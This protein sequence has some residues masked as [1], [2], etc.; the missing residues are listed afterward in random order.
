MGWLPDFQAKVEFTSLDHHIQPPVRTLRFRPSCVSYKI[1]RASKSLSK[2][3][4]ASDD[5]AW[6]DSPVMSRNHAEIYIN[7]D[8]ESIMLKDIGSLHGTFIN[9]TQVE[10]FTPIPI[11]AGDTIV[12]GAPVARN[13]ETFP[14]CSFQVYVDL[15]DTTAYSNTF[16]LPSSSDVEEEPYNIISDDER[17]HVD[18]S[19]SSDASSVVEEVFITKAANVEHIGDEIVSSFSAANDNG[20]HIVIDSDE[21]MSVSV[22]DLESEVADSDSSDSASEDIQEDEIEELE[23]QATG[24]TVHESEMAEYSDYNQNTTSDNADNSDMEPSAQQSYGIR[25]EVPDDMSDDEI[26]DDQQEH[27]SDTELKDMARLSNEPKTSPDAPWLQASSFKFVAEAPD[28]FGVS[29]TKLPDI[30]MPPQRIYAGPYSLPPMNKP[31]IPGTLQTPGE[32][33]EGSTSNITDSMSDKKE[34]FDAW[35][36]NRETLLKQANITPP[37]P[38]QNSHDNSFLQVEREFSPTP[39]YGHGKIAEQDPGTEFDMTSAVT[40]N[41]SKQV[42]IPSSTPL[43][44]E[45]SILTKS[46]PI[47]N[48]THRSKVSINDIIDNVSTAESSKRK[49]KFDQISELVEEEPQSSTPVAPQL[50]EPQSVS[51]RPIKK[52]KSVAEIA[53]WVALGGIGIFSILVATAPDL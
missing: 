6:F 2:G 48:Q 28:L 20:N 19:D 16:A 15:H 35:A 50:A 51:Q 1:G 45:P 49:R 9:G 11:N 47:V 22:E 12:F 14:P 39:F 25:F 33:W 3:I 44:P 40:F 26:E 37:E 17:Q 29:P 52:L 42:I 27:D 43:S 18:I 24:P 32:L 36:G 8:I 34:F 31:D 13:G 53:G 4:V 23:E 5:N 46:D 30:V 38:E 41:R 7:P 21:E 10:R